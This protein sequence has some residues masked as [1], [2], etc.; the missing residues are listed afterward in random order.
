MN[1]T[2]IQN[3]M[4]DRARIIAPE[5]LDI[6][7][8]LEAGAGAGKTR[9]IVD[10]ILCQLRVGH[11][12]PGEIVVITFT[13]KAAEELRGRITES[14][15]ESVK[16]ATGKEHDNLQY[17]LNHMDDMNISTIHSFCFKLLKEKCFEVDLPVDTKLMDE[18]EHK[19]EMERLFDAWMSSWT[20]MDWERFT[21]IKPTVKRRDIRRDLYDIYERICGLQSDVKVVNGRTPDD[22]QANSK[23][24]SCLAKALETELV[25]FVNALDASAGVKNL[26]DVAIYNKGLGAQYILPENFDGALEAAITDVVS[27]VS[28][29]ACLLYDYEPGKEVKFRSV[30]N[31]LRNP[32]QPTS[33][34]KDET[35]LD[36]VT[37]Q[38]IA[39]VESI[40]EKATEV[41][42]AAKSAKATPEQVAACDSFIDDYAKKFALLVSPLWSDINISNITD[43]LD[44]TKVPKYNNYFGKTWSINLAEM[45][46]DPNRDNAKTLKKILDIQEGKSFFVDKPQEKRKIYDETAFSLAAEPFKEW[47]STNQ[48]KIETCFINGDLR[49]YDELLGKALEAKEYYVLNHNTSKVSN[50]SLLEKTRD[51]ILQHDDVQAY[52]AE[53]Y[54][55]FYV[56]EF[57]DTDSIQEAFIWR[58]ATIPGD[59]TK[60]RDGAL[61]IVGD[62]KQ[63]IY[64]FR[65]AQPDVYM[66]VQK[67][68]KDMQDRG[69]NV[70]T[71]S[72]NINFR[73]N[74]LIIEW[75]NEKFSDTGML[76]IMAN[77]EYIY[78]DMIPL[79]LLP[80]DLAIRENMWAL[81]ID[82]PTDNII[83]GV[84]KYG[85]PEKSVKIHADEESQQLTDLIL[86]LVN[87]EKYKIVDYKRVGD[88]YNVPF[89]RPIVF[90]DFM[91]LCNGLKQMNIYMDYLSA[92]GIDVQIAGSTLPQK[93]LEINA[94]VRI[95]DYITN[96][97]DQIA[98]EAAL[99]SFRLLDD[100]WNSEDID[101]WG[102]GILDT[103]FAET[104][105]M[106]PFGMARHLLQRISLLFSKDNPS[107]AFQLV[108]IQSKIEQ[109]IEQVCSQDVGTAKD[110]S[111]KFKE[112]LHTQVEHELSLTEQSGAVQFMNVHK[113]KGLEGNIVVIMDRRRG[114]NAN[115]FTR[116]GNEY[117]PNI[118]YLGEVKEYE[119]KE[120]LSDRRRLEY[121][122][123][124]RAAKALVFMDQMS[125][126]CLFGGVDKKY[127]V[128]TLNYG[129]SDL[130]SISRAVNE[131]S[132]GTRKPG[133][134]KYSILDEEKRIQDKQLILDEGERLVKSSQSVSPSSFEDSHANLKAQY[135]ERA[136]AEGKTYESEQ[137]TSLFRPVGNIFGDA[138]HMTMENLVNRYSQIKT[139]MKERILESCVNQAILAKGD[140]IVSEEKKKYH[141]FLLAAAKAYYDYLLSSGLLEGDIKICTELPF[142]YYEHD[143]KDNAGQVARANIHLDEDKKLEEI[144]VWMNGTADLVLVKSDSIEIIDYKSDNDYLIYDDDFSDYLRKKYLGQLDNYKYAMAKVFS[145]R[146]IDESKISMKIIS[147]SQ[148]DT[149]GNLLPGEEVRVRVTQME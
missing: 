12:A 41:H 109:M 133:E 35:A 30:D 107:S 111:E 56:D 138:L 78:Q 120:Y 33:W 115:S 83:A 37:S 14:L 66:D 44:E 8:F 123:A 28:L 57:Q 101:N 91:I 40:R 24:E 2:I 113:S 139:N 127:G 74:N 134:N 146:N 76:P 43:I 53:K 103:L 21:D 118:K 70:L 23:N 144:P 124:T 16:K 19:E 73:S 27:D 36:D 125:S 100:C 122:A 17:A 5:N 1:S 147:F 3:E 145:D 112:Y 88:D 50:D 99:E 93:F 51:L 4:N 68:M 81:S 60:L 31:L 38:I 82:D 48:M 25:K 121:V 52:F 94:F 84:Y 13:N 63:S 20:K 92:H 47:V 128:E 119:Q 77:S 110:V 18:D 10:R 136:K 98:R 130:H 9:A 61:F 105:G 46:A 22:P 71:Y 90:K 116:I 96:R 143:G 126:P 49:F 54:K 55:T 87:N 64:R 67:R 26:K 142:S 108:S 45:I 89:L 7:M 75:V 42:K 85:S 102:R 32:E 149:I 65:G 141:D 135:R 6:N 106:S 79:K 29:L 34:N 62:P 69:E 140:E 58:L 15:T 72:L 39:Y 117:Y 137:S 104:L 11:R 95:Y 59:A 132:N 80:A 86:N 97:K 129:L 114:R 148:K 131:C